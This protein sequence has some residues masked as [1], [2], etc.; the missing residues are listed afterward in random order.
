MRKPSIPAV[1]I[2]DQKISSLL[3]PMKQ[4]IEIMTGL[5]G[6]PISELPSNATTAQIISTINAIIV[7]LNA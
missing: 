3:R 1:N 2:P 7:R 6:D 5:R 4:N